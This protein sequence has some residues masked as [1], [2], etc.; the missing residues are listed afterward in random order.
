MS[1]APR[2]RKCSLAV[3]MVLAFAI[4]SSAVITTSPQPSQERMPNPD[5][6]C[7]PPPNTA[8]A[9]DING[10]GINDWLLAEV[11][12]GRNVVQEWCIVNFYLLVVNGFACGKCP[13][14]DGLNSLW[15]DVILI[16][17]DQHMRTKWIAAE[18]Y[19]DDGDGKFDSVTYICDVYNEQWLS[20]SE[21]E[22]GEFKLESQ[23]AIIHK[24][25]GEIVEMIILQPPPPAYRPELLH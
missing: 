15:R 8:R 19:D 23:V 11:R 12:R 13:F 18:R 20:L 6:P 1:I 3:M 4:A 5:D 16:N 10:D 14:R 25:D 21:D 2:D 24:E 9:Y 17:R 7:P 22:T